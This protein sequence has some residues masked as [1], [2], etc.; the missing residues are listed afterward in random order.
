MHVP[1]HAAHAWNNRASEPAVTVIVTGPAIWRFFT[2]VAG[3]PSPETLARFAAVAARYGHWL[4][5]PEENM[6]AGIALSGP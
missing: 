5:T 1:G 3:R 4:G 6:A 2:E